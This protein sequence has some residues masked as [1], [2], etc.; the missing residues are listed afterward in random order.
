MT[1]VESSHKSSGLLLAMSGTEERLQFVLGRPA[2]NG[3]SLLASR[4]WTVPGESI[5]F[6]T[7]GIKET[8]DTMGLTVADIDRIA[9]TRG[10]GSFT[11]LRLVL[12]AAEGMA[13]GSGARL[14]GIDYLS[15]LAAG[16]GPLLTG[17][18]HVLTYARRGL[19]YFQSFSAPSMTEITSLGSVTL[20]EAAS[21]INECDSP[22]FVMGTGI[23][24]NLSFFHDEKAKLSRCTLLSSCWDNPSPEILLKAA[25]SAEYSQTSIA[26]IY[27]RATDAEDNLPSIAKKRG[28]DPEKA[29]RQLTELQNN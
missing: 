26:P 25:G 11:G 20:E 9:C 4:E 28:I 7:P 18:L 6:L 21:R 3:Y 2:E 17:T 5:R 24:K 27:V 29:K 13:A 14:A 12:A 8:L 10:P 1:S 15:L 23:R 19:V 16:P 22:C